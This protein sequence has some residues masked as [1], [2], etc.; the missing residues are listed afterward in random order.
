MTCGEGLHEQLS[1]HA[2]AH[3]RAYEHVPRHARPVPLDATEVVDLAALHGRVPAATGRHH[4]H[5]MARTAT[6]WSLLRLWPLIRLKH[7][8]RG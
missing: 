6:R 2:G 5:D 3:V 1:E 7:S 8:R 4:Q